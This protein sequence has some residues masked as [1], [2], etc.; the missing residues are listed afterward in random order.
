MAKLQP[1]YKVVTPREDLREGK[2]LDAAE[3]AVH[4]DK[5]RTGQAPADYKVPDRFFDRTYLTGTLLDMAAQVV[6]RLSGQVTETS[7][8]FNMATQF[9]GG[10][11]HALALLYHLAKGGKTAIKWQGVSKVLETAGIVKVPDGCAIAVF[12]GTEFDS[13]VGR[14]GKD[15]TP[16]RKTPWGEIAFQ[17]GGED[18]FSVVASHDEQF[19]E[20][21][22]DVINAFLPKERPCL[23]LMD[24]I[25]NYVS[26][27]RDQG[28]HNKLYNFVQSLSETVRGRNNAVLVVSIPKSELN[29]TDRDEQDQ[30]RFKNMLDRLGKAVV[31]SVEEETAE[32]I[33]RR[34][35]E[36]EPKAVSQ[37]GKVLLTKEAI[38]AC[39]EYA[40]WTK[41]HQQQ[42]P[43]WFPIDHAQSVF[44][45]TYPFHPSVLS[46]FERKW[47]EMPRFQ[48]TRGILRLLALWVSE[49]YQE[50]WKT[51]RPDATIGL[52]SAPMDNPV[53]RTALLEQLGEQRLEGVITTDICGKKESHS[54][55]LDSEAIDTIKKTQLHK[56]IATSIFFESNG[57]RTRNEASVPEVRL[58]VSDPDL[59]I[60]NIETVLDAL[61]STCYYL[62]ARGNQYRF[63][64]QEN[65]NKRF[66][67]RS[68]NI[69]SKHIDERV[70]DEVQNAF[71]TING[72]E[73][74]FFPEKSGQIPDRPVVTMVIMSPDSSS[75][76]NSGFV[77]QVEKMTREHGQSAR[78]YKNA[79]IWV[80]PDSNSSLSIEARKLLAWE[81]IENEGL[82]LDEAQVRQLDA[83]LKK[84]NRD[85]KEAVWRT[86]NKIMLLGQDN[87][88]HTIDLG[89]PTSSAAESMTRYI[90]NILRQSDE[91]EADFV[92]PR[93]LLK[94]WPPALVEWSTR[95]VRDAFFASPLF[96]RLLN[97]LSVK[98]TIA[99]GV[100][101][102]LLAYVGKLP[103]GSYDPLIFKSTLDLED[104]E[105]SDDTYIIKGEEA[106]KHLQPPT[107]SKLVLTPAQIQLKPGTSQAF[108]AKGLDQHGQDIDTGSI[109]WTATGG[110]VDKNGV[111]EAGDQEGN[112]F[113]TAVAGEIAQTAGITIIKQ[114]ELTPPKPQEL[115]DQR[116]SLIWSGEIIPQKWMNFYTRVLTKYVQAGGLTL[117]IAFRA[118]PPE[119]ITEQQIEETKA[120]LRELGLDDNVNI[121]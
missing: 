85:L 88:L 105:I 112:F 103:S 55:R 79:L 104:I 83:S 56:R 58:A 25:I 120:S 96:P 54:C 32:I 42:I 119:G 3:F 37:E 13:L 117:N 118:N 50:S 35:F 94:K 86:Y 115:P 40:E 16:F 14:G 76:D 4:L 45:A 15:G 27:Y 84:A 2:P 114:L 74:V 87:A 64:T 102:G 113:V 80:I 5:I 107:L 23:I 38:A 41:E 62:E 61:Y 71:P 48:Q 95:N 78:T 69:N 99:R 60:G 65:L 101:E 49:A 97:P 77:Q 98:A 7:A 46:V 110:N 36:W 47:Q 66:A 39:H 20:P 44:E 33:R 100:S 67:D 53:F 18:A 116:Q 30:Q 92:S 12:V 73:R 31:M 111:F 6:R 89:M 22:G 81:D 70:K 106:E 90:I 121:E 82:K 63:T 8:V 68:A 11:T 1:W 10:K 43:Q 72:L 34:L 108:I 57:G 29:Y 17:L 19:I 51:N 24:E 93:L 109:E 28:F 75:Q 91:I 26:T 59:D 9:G 21:K 52:G